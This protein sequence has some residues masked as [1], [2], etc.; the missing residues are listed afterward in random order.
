M[1]PPVRL[2]CLLSLF[3][4][5][6]CSS[7]QWQEAGKNFG[8]AAA[9]Q[10][11]VL[12]VGGMDGLE[13]YNDRKIEKDRRENNP[14]RSSLTREELIESQKRAEQ[15]ELYDDILSKQQ[16]YLKQA[17]PGESAGDRLVCASE[18]SWICY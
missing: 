5:G 17:L 15:W 18:S 13:E 12:A 3:L 4:L 16:D 14:Y 1:N 2:F 10:L 11:F 9:E 8:A 6:G 7:Y